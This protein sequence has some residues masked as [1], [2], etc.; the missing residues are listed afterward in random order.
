MEN[1][2]QYTHP[3]RDAPRPSHSHPAKLYAA[4]AHAN[5]QRLTGCLHESAGPVQFELLT[6]A[7]CCAVATEAHLGKGLKGHSIK[8]NKSWGL[9]V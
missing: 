8:L 6:R 2:P 1:T 7:L 4:H 9:W 5:G 3:K